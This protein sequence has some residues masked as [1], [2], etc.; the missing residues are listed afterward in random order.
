MII[1]VKIVLLV[2][3]ALFYLMA[4]GAKEEKKAYSNLGAGIVTTVLLL[5]AMK[6]L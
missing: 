3:S 1:A 2:F 4:M 6:I 5:V